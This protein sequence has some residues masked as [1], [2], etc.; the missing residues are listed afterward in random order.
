VSGVAASP[1]RQRL[2]DP[3]SVKLVVRVRNVDAAFARVRDRIVC[4]EG[5][6]PMKPE[7]PAAVNTAVIMRDP[8]GFPLEFAMQDTPATF[9]VGDA[10][11]TPR[12]DGAGVAGHPGATGSTSAGA[13]PREH[14]FVI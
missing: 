11:A 14:S 8:D 7:G 9:I 10:A 13:R 1:V 12:A 4:T 3:G 5:G 2:Q 6:A